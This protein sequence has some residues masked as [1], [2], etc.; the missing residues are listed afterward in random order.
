[1]KSKVKKVLRKMV[2]LEQECQANQNNA[3]LIEANMQKMLEL[4]KS[5]PL[6]DFIQVIEELEKM[7]EKGLLS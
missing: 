1:M 7:R 3:R 2:K 5:I 6:K 4:G